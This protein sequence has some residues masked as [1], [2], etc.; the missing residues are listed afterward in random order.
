VKRPFL[1]KFSIRTAYLAVPVALIGLLAA[2]QP[3]ATPDGVTRTYFI[4]ADEVVW[5]YAPSG[6]NVITGKEFGEEED[7]WMASGPTR[8]GRVYKKALYREYT[9]STFATLKPRPSEWEHLGILGPLI[10]AEVGDTVR[11]IYRNNVPFPTSLHP[12]GV[13]YDKDSEGAPYEDL[14]DEREADNSTVFWMYHS[15]TEEVRDVNAGLIGPMIVHARGTLG[16]DGRPTDVDREVILSFLEFNENESWFIEEN[17]R[18][19]MSSPDVIMFGRGPFGDRI[20]TS[21]GL[22]WGSNFM[23]TLN[24]FSYGHLEGLTMREG[25]RVR[26]YMM[27]ST[28]FEIHAPHWHGNTVTI[29]R[30]RTDMS[31]LLPMGMAVAEMVPDNPGT[32]L[33][34]CHVAQHLQGGMSAVYRVL[35]AA[36]GASPLEES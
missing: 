11:I 17:V 1:A 2:C 31:A 20:A 26:W 7:H 16:S 23:E 36:T 27:A 4:A 34:H 29:G 19:Y 21:D 30:M 15:H 22:D 12:H 3:T 13:F 25:E 6:A 5:D 18:T 9:D 33:V 32:W 35:P 8:V 24:G 10:R 14:T 28:N